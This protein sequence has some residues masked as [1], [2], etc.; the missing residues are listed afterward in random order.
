MLDTRDVNAAIDDYANRIKNEVLGSNI[1]FVADQLIAQAEGLL[2]DLEALKTEITAA[3][4]GS[5]PI[6]T[7][8]NLQALADLINTTT[9][10][11]GGDVLT[12]SVVGDDLALVLDHQ[13]ATTITA[14][15]DAAGSVGFAADA[16]DLDASLILDA[17]ARFSLA[18]LVDGDDGS[19][20]VDADA[21]SEEFGLSL[22]GDLDVCRRRHGSLG[23]PRYLGV[24]RAGA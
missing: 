9:F 15:L 4:G 6:G 10:L 14:T 11:G 16:I 12:A 13:A 7:P 1:P 19:V 24:G 20:S 23:L 22:E 3:L 18:L 17:E 8:A 21:V 2:A 5:I